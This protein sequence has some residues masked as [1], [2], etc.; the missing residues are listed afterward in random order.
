MTWV[1]ASA[2]PALVA[3]IQ[4]QAGTTCSVLDRPPTTVNPPLIVVGRPSQVLYSTPSFGI[5]TATVPIACIGA[6]D[7][8]EQVDALV[9][10]VRAIADPALSDITLGHVVQLVGDVAERG[11]RNLVIAGVDILQATVDLSITM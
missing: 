4:V 6:A 2:Q 3:A 7:S 11:W 9:T 5:D 1:R 10:I 8:D